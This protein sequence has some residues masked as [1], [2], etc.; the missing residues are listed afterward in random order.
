M[1]ALGVTKHAGI[2]S[3]AYG[4][5]RPLDPSALVPKFANYLLRTPGYAAEYLRR[6]TGVRSGEMAPRA[7]R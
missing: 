1:A 5:Y 6:S 4:V 3:P 7:G 2:V